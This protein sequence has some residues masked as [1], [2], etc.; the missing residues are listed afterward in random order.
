MCAYV[1]YIMSPYLFASVC[2]VLPVYMSVSSSAV[3][4]LGRRSQAAS[5]GDLPEFVSLVH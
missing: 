2:Y 5:R 1:Q 3:W 4:L